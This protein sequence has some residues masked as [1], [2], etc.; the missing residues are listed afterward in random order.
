MLG[1]D[2]GQLLLRVRLLI[3]VFAILPRHAPTEAAQRTA[4]RDRD[5][6]STDE[7]LA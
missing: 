5:Q 3:A 2:I 1:L 6:Q 7:G 4:Q